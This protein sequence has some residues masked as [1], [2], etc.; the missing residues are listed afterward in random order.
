MSAVAPLVHHWTRT[1]YEH[2]VEAGVFASGARIELLDGEIIAMS[3]QGPQHVTATQLVA[4]ALR[5]RLPAGY[6]VRVQAP[7]ALDDH[8]EPEPDIC[9]VRGKVRDY[10]RSHPSAALL[11]IEVSDS[12]LEQDRTVKARAYARNGIPEYWVVNVKE[13]VVEV[14]TKPRAGGYGQVQVLREQDDIAAESVAGV[15]MAVADLLP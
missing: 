5:E 1:E 2:M 11:V 9:V 7:I 15:R 6:L 14:Y 8:C 12:S 10:A 3:P 13:R 4:E